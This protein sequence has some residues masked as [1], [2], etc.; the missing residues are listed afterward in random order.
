MQVED[1]GGSRYAVNFAKRIVVKVGTSTITYENG[2]MNH[3]NI[4]RLCRG[5][6]D[7]WN[8]GR[9]II[10][11]TSGAIAPMESVF[12]VASESG[13]VYFTRNAPVQEG[14]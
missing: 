12:Y 6:A 2:K 11:V 10:L 8:S 4:D 13:T 7:I 9:E 1:K 3:G 5:I 14:E